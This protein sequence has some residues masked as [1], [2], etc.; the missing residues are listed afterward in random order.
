M[1]HLRYVAAVVL[2]AGLTTIGTT[3]P[4]HAGGGGGDRVIRSGACSDGARWKIKAKEDDG[5]IEVEAEIDS[6]VSGQRWAWALRHNGTLSGKGTARTAG[7]S[8]SF[9][10]QR[11]VVD[12]PGTDSFTF[13]ATHDSQ[14]CVARLSY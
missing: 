4:A 5:R 10:I 8:G 3:V 14:T 9:E 2:A 7:A 1:R 13:R 6:N 11:K 12:K